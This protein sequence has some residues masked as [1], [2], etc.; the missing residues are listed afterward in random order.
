MNSRLTVV[1]TGPVTAD[2]LSERGL[3]VDVL[4]S[5]YLFEETLAELV[6]HW[7]VK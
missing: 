1:A 5:R 4:P 6:L 7:S 3:R 2:A